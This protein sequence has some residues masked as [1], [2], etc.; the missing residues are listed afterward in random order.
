MYEKCGE[1]KN[2]SYKF[3]KFHG[4]CERKTRGRHACSVKYVI[5]TENIREKLKI[6]VS[7]I[8]KIQVLL[9][10]IPAPESQLTSCGGIL[11]TSN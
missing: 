2:S 4:I 7:S 3:Y 11:S 8:K 6:V 5:A 10:Q 9:R 1:Q